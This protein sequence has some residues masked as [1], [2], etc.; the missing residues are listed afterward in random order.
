M[1]EEVEKSCTSLGTHRWYQ[2]YLIDGVW[3]G[4]V[5]HH[6]IL[7]DPAKQ[8]HEGGVAFRRPESQKWFPSSVPLFDYNIDDQGR[9][10]V[11]DLI[12]CQRCGQQGYITSDRWYDVTDQV[13]PGKI[14]PDA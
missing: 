3:I 11:T 4:I 9:L 8:E 13:G 1:R 2:R 6:P 7:N 5:E 14:H 12:T 10:T